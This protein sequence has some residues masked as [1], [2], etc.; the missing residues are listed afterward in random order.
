VQVAKI[1]EVVRGQVQRLVRHVV[2]SEKAFEFLNRQA[3]LPNDC[4]QCS[5][6]YF[7]V[8]GNGQASMGWGLLSQ[9]HVAASL[10]V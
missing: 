3:G 9:N 4:S 2:G 6:S 5:L 8:V 1:N 7:L 10:P